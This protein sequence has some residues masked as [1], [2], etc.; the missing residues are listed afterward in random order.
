M[1]NFSS[2]SSKGFCDGRSELRH[3]RD[4]SRISLSEDWEC[5]TWSKTL[6]VSKGRLEE[7]VKDHGNST[8]AIHAALGK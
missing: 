5:F 1:Q 6:S 2:L 3:R 8:K 7:L 4:A